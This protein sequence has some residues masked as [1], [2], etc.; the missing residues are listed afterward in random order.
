MEQLQTLPDEHCSPAIYYFAEQPLWT[1]RDTYNLRLQ[2]A[3]S[4]GEVPR[5]LS[6]TDLGRLENGI[7]EKVTEADDSKGT[8]RNNLETTVKSVLGDK[9]NWS[10]NRKIWIVGLL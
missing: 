2:T 3:V 5:H 1:Q 10:V 8:C 9:G 6:A 4:L 7:W